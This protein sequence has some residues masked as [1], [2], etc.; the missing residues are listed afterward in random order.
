MWK[1]N[2]LPD[3]LQHIYEVGETG[4]KLSNTLRTELE[5]KGTKNVNGMKL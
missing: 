1:E 4:L 2:Q 3:K 5:S